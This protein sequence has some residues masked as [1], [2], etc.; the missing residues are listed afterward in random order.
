MAHCAHDTYSNLDGVAVY[1]TFV[2]VTML[3]AIHAGLIVI[4]VYHH[5]ACPRIGTL[6]PWGIATGAL[7]ITLTLLGIMRAFYMTTGNGLV[8]RLKYLL[9]ICAVALSVWGIVITFDNLECIDSCDGCNNT[10]YIIAFALSVIY[11][12]NVA[13]SCAAACCHACVKVYGQG[14]DV[15]QRL[16]MEANRHLPM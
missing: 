12:F 13:L 1:G 2:T 16:A 4:S 6:V 8:R 15:P 10:L 9:G 3:L 14:G 11:M 7:G 5:D